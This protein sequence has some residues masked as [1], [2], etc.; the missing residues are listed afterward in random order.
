MYNPYPCRTRLQSLREPST[1]DIV[2]LTKKC[3]EDPVLF[4]DVKS[5]NMSIHVC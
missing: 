5:I 3:P 1:I 4:M 2:E